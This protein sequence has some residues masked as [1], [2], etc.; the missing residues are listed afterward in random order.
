MGKVL[1]KMYLDEAT[2]AAVDELAERE[3]RSRSGML[4]VIVRHWISQEEPIVAGQHP[5]PEV[6]SSGPLAGKTRTRKR[7]G[8]QSSDRTPGELS[9]PPHGPAPGAPAAPIDIP[10]EGPPA[11][12]T[13]AP[14]KPHRHRFV[15]EVAGTRQGR[16]GI[17]QADFACA[18]GQTK[19]QAVR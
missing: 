1:V 8:N 10:A 12:S 5:T 13:D 4:G 16:A 18:C 14:G 15:T 19:R 9:P 3:S 17:I 6:V 2:V 7:G 11:G